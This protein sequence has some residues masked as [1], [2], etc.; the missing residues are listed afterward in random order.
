[1]LVIG[2]T[3]KKRHGKG[4]VGEAIKRLVPGAKACGFAD[5][6]KLC[7][8]RSLGFDR[9]EPELIA[10][11]DSFKESGN[12]TIYYDDP[13][14]EHYDRI[15]HELNGRQYL[16][17][18]GT[19]GGRETFGKDFWIDQVLP[20]AMAGPHVGDDLM[21][22]QIHGDIPILAITDIRFDNEAQR[23]KDVGGEVWQVRRPDLGGQGDGHIS[24]AGVS[25]YLIDRVILN[26]GT[27]ENLEW[28]VEC[29]LELAQ[30]TRD[31]LS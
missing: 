24:E 1:M 5:K 26:N 9:P 2:I 19:E 12:F 31:A 20:P 30:E 16:Q 3:G 4:E 28:R 22:R 8:M 10:L 17:W 23:V 6:L 25:D 13:E 18:M 15:L 11:A 29:A 7:A 21:L 14:V 27:L